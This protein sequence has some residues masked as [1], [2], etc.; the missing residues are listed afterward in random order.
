MLLCYF[1]LLVTSGLTFAV[2]IKRLITLS[3]EE[4]DMI[5][6][7]I[8]T[9]ADYIPV[10]QVVYL[11]VTEP[12]YQMLNAETDAIALV[13]HLRVQKFLDSLTVFTKATMETTN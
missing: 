5:F 13:T 10:I 12:F 9:K 2:E 7:M 1:V 8:Q 3:E 11:Q 6:S 4:T